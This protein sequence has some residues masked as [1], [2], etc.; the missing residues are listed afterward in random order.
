MLAGED[1]VTD[2]NDQL[3]MLVVEPSACM[4]RIGSG[5][6]KDGVS[7][8]HFAWDQ[9]LA[10]AEVLKRALSLRAPEF[11]SRNIYFAEA[12]CF[13]ANSRHFVFSF[14]YSSAWWPSFVDSSPSCGGIDPERDGQPTSGGLLKVLKSGSASL[15]LVREG[16]G[17]FEI[18]D[19]CV[20]MYLSRAAKPIGFRR[21]R[22][23]PALQRK[24]RP[25]RFVCCHNYSSNS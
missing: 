12:V 14:V 15:P 23:Q 8:N 21:G 19:E 11:V 4:I 6:L 1:L 20:G 24:N 18:D 22:E 3:M 13:L 16:D 25:A 7:G 9:V 5:F 10:D 17:I 2:L